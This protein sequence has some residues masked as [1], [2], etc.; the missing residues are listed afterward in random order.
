MSGSTTLEKLFVR[1]YTLEMLR[2]E[3]R[4]LVESGILSYQQPIFNL[5]SYIPAR[6]WPYLEQALERHDF[7]LRDRIIDLLSNETWT[8]D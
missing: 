6:E 1:Q 4:Q 5:C 8:E 3:A 7:L 2:D